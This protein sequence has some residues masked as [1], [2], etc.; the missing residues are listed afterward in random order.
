LAAY[1]AAM[2]NSRNS[3]NQ[4][5]APVS[6]PASNVA[7]SPVERLHRAAAAAGATLLVTM[8][9]G[10][11]PLTAAGVGVASAAAQGS[12][13]EQTQGAAQPRAATRSSTAAAPSESGPDLDVAADFSA[14]GVDKG[15]KLIGWAKAG[16]MVFG[17]LGL[18]GGVVIGKVLKESGNHHASGVR[19]TGMG[20]GG[21]MVLAGA[22]PTIVPW[23]MG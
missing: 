22:A 1:K 16:A 3:E 19:A 14:P 18:I 4:S 21:A 13:L 9:I 23:L 20:I 8:S 17:V 6:P 2:T 10:G 7:S 11:G 5:I 12:V 15:K